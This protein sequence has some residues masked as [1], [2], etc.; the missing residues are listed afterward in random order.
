MGK[1]RTEPPTSPAPAGYF[2]CRRGSHGFVLAHPARCI[3]HAAAARFYTWP[4]ETPKQI[5]GERR[6]A[7]SPRRARHLP[8]GD[9]ATH[10]LV[11]LAQQRGDETCRLRIPTTFGLAVSA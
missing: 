9:P 11:N 2:G 10:R 8:T 6:L 3:L 7:H 4:A 1:F 5:P